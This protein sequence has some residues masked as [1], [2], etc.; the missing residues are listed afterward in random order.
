MITLAEARALV[1]EA[2]AG[3]RLG[4]GKVALADALGRVLA[5]ELR[6]PGDVPG[7]R[8][9]AM[10]GYALHGADLAEDGSARLE[11]AGAMLAGRAQ[12]MVLPR[13]ACARITTGAPMPDG[14]DTVAIQ[15]R[16]RVDGTVI[17]VSDTPRGANV[18]GADDDYAAG[19]LA[20]SAGVRLASSHL[21]VASAFGLA[22]V[23]VRAQPRV[24]ALVTGD[25]LVSAP[26]PLGFGQRYDSNAALL[27]AL[28]AEHGA[29]VRVLRAGDDLDG[30][31]N[32]LLAAAGESDLLITTGGASVGEADF[33]PA[34]ARRHGRIVFHKLA[35]R[36]GM[37]ALFGAIGDTPLFAL[38]GNPDS[39]SATFVA[40]VRPALAVL[41][42][43]PALDPAP[44][45]VRLA[46][47]MHKRHTRLELRR[48]RLE[49]G[50]GGVLCA[51]PHP[52]LSSGA[53]RSLAES[54]AL[55]E[56]AA[57]QSQFEGGSVVPAHPLNLWLP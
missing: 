29:S 6:A 26:A 50:P 42:A 17:D 27:A 9:S 39:V 44:F 56:L 57:E 2:F 41:C 34:V 5:S 46:A 7:F 40:L 15:E 20:V 1:R 25:E 16:C 21:G 51:H 53:L 28:C 18:R 10:D 4:S 13:G 38:P 22:E 23:E 33:L 14:A 55:L 48:G 19:D 12:P 54:D 11:L 37:P 52:T 3:R 47:P 36:P 32:A 43:C 8:I 31:A 35:L 49:R 30:I 24:T 45:E